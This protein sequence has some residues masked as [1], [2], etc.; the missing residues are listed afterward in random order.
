MANVVRRRDIAEAAAS[1]L[2]ENGRDS[3][4]MREVA[5]RLGVRAPSLYKHV[6]GKDEIEELVAERGWATLSSAV[7]AA[8]DT[9]AAQRRFALDHPA[10]YL[11]M[12]E[13][14]PE[15]LPPVS[16]ERLALGH[17]LALLEL[18]GAD[19]GSP[20]RQAVVRSVRGP[21]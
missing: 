6:S 7:S 12:A 9:M 14:L 15:V 10:L 8:A 18:A 2:A 21:D 3:L 4:T 16:L 5:S 11:L 1:L 19:V 20:P 13:R 17:G